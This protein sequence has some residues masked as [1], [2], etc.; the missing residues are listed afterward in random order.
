MKKGHSAKHCRNIMKCF[1]CNG[2]HHVTV[3]T[4]QNRVNVPKN[5]SIFLQTA[6][7]RV[8]SVD[9]KNC[10]KFRI[11]FVMDPSCYISAHKL[12]KI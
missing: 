7:T 10:Q 11:L 8:I 12:P 6:P 9:E 4:F 3:C 2:R 5:D 1:K